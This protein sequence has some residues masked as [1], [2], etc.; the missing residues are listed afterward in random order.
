MIFYDFLWIFEFEGTKKPTSHIGSDTT[1]LLLQ[2]LESLC[3]L[4]RIR[5]REKSLVVVN[6]R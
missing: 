5:S 4:S 2:V 1:Q 3:P 6:S